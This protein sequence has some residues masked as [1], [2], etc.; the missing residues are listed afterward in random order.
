MIVVC[1]PHFNYLSEVFRLVEIGKVLR[2]LEQEVVFFSQCR[3][4]ANGFSWATQ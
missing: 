4:G 1:Y 3:Q 2:R